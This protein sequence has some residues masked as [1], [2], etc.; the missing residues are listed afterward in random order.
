MITGLSRDEKIKKLREARKSLRYI[1]N[2]FGISGERVRQVLKKMGVSSMWV[3]RFPTP[4]KRK[5]FLKSCGYVFLI[6]TKS[7][8]KRRF[9]SSVCSVKG[10]RTFN[11]KARKD[12]TKEDWKAYWHHKNF[13]PNT[14]KLRKEYYE[15]N[16]EKIKKYRQIP[17]IKARY[18][19]YVK[20][21]YELNKKKLAA[22]YKERYKN[23]A[24]FREKR[25]EYFRN[26]Y[27]RK[28]LK[29]K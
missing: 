28:K 12:W 16:K 8:M 27:L 18:A 9:C 23:D 17:E 19:G 4:I 1:G 2:E 3:N 26:Y 25:A 7:K 10:K 20:K 13:A 24:K 21:W 14:V 15:K 29:N 6:H 5:C 22:K 11:G